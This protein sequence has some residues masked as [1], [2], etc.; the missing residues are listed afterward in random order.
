MVFQSRIWRG[1][2]GVEGEEEEE[3]GRAGNNESE[4]EWILN[5]FGLKRERERERQER[6]EN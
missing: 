6:G 1:W 5:N 4:S 2:G 3:G